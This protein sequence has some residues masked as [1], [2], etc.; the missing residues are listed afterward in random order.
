MK[1]FKFVQ[2]ITHATKPTNAERTADLPITPF[3]RMFVVI[4]GR[5]F[6]VQEVRAVAGSE[7]VTVFLRNNNKYYTEKVDR[8]LAFCVE[9]E[10]EGWTIEDWEKK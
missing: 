3:P 8:L 6:L 2:K 10:S 1:S 5:M 9:M 4:C 7:E